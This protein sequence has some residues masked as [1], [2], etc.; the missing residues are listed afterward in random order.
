MTSESIQKENKN[1]FQPQR[2]NLPILWTPILQK[3]LLFVLYWLRQD[4]KTQNFGFVSFFDS[5]EKKTTVWHL[6]LP[7]TVGITKPSIDMWMDLELRLSSPSLKAELFLEATIQTAKSLFLDIPNEKGLFFR[8][9]RIGRKSRFKCCIFVYLERWR[10]F[11]T[12]H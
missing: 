2:R 8:V 12:S 7:F 9:D 4:L 10:S 6:M 3:W 1:C 5:H 11:K